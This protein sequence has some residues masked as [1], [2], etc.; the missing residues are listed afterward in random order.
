MQALYDIFEDKIISSGIWP[1]R[2]PNLNPC[3]F[4]FWGCLKDNVYNI[5]P[6]KE[7]IKENV[8]KEIANIAA[9]DL[10]RVNQNVFHWCKEY[11][12]REA[13]FFNTS[14]DL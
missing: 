8:H 6:P 5:N 12:C 3:D 11:L 4:S 9:E 2:S 7:E 14:C 1:V 10:Q 13:S